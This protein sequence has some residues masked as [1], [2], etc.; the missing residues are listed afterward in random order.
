ML[1][2][3]RK[4]IFLQNK[5][6]KFEYSEWQTALEKRTHPNINYRVLIQNKSLM[7]IYLSL[8]YPYISAFSC[9]HQHTR[10]WIM[11]AFQFWLVK[12]LPIQDLLR[13]IGTS[14]LKKNMKNLNGN[15]IFA[16][17]EGISFRFCITSWRARKW[18][19][20]LTPIEK[21]GT[22]TF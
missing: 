10:L 16:C 15:A 18:Y 3:L 9:T 7:N 21:V 19:P 12:A 11:C 4:N 17:L 1:E 20:L 5:L 2:K 13:D 8:T 14:K 6:N 22:I